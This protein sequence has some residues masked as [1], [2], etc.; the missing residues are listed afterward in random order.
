MRLLI[1]VALILLQWNYSYSQKPIAFPGAEGCGKYTTGGRGGKVIY[2]NNLNDSGEGS[3][4]HALTKTRGKRTILFS[5]SGTIYLKSI[6]EVKNGDF[7]LA[8][9]SA[10]GDGI[11]V[12]G[13]GIDIDGADNIIIRYM[14]FRP[15]DIAG[16]ETDAL[17]IK[18]CKNVMVDHCSMSWSTDETCSC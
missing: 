17:T 9:H 3:L 15:G 2:V 7:T 12:A 11:C 16:N 4:R 13:D 14:R 18:R 10:P 5:I 1:L 8:G 6:I